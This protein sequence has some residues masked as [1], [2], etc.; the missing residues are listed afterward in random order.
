MSWY[1]HWFTDDM[2]IELYAHRDATEARQAIDLFEEVTSLQPEQT[3]A[4]QSCTASITGAPSSGTGPLLDLACGNGRHAVELAS[5]GHTVIAA[6]LSPTLLRVA[7]D[8]TQRYRHRIGLLR[9]DM[10]RLPFTHSFSAVLQ[11]FTA[12]G[13]FRRDAENEAVINGVRSCLPTGGWYMLD[14]LNAEAVTDTIVPLTETQTSRGTVT[15][16]RTIRDGRVEKRICIREDDQEREFTES[17]RLFTYDDFDRMFTRN[18]FELA[19]VY[20]NYDGA[21]YET[22][23]PRCL[24]FARAT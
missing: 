2:Y 10:R 4:P 24:M 5:R 17:V 6:D 21:P 18:A 9:T 15:Q 23:S 19:E 1:T 13:Y 12:F 7:A 14:F 22:D 3:R 20:G 16:K 11:L 8:K